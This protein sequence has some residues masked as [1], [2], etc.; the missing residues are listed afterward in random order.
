MQNV[1]PMGCHEFEAH[2]KGRRRGVRDHQGGVVFKS[3][4]AVKRRRKRG[5]GEVAPRGVCMAGDDKLE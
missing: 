2:G 3:G 1:E 4:P 5:A